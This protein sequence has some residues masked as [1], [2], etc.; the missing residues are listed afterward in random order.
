VSHL[1]NCLLIRPFAACGRLRPPPD[2]SS[3]SAMSSLGVGAF[4]SCGETPNWHTP[5]YSVNSVVI[6]AQILPA[7]IST[8]LYLLRAKQLILSFEHLQKA[9]GRIRPTAVRRWLRK[10]R[11]HHNLNAD[12]QPIT[13]LTLFEAGINNRRA[14]GDVIHEEPDFDRLTASARRLGSSR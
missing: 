3:R 13:T 1:L 7:E 10:H 2:E 14:K 5:V 8:S 11:I 12:G 4:G 6:A 9:S